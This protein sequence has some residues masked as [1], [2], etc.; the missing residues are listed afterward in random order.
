MPEGVA[1]PMKYQ[2]RPLDRLDALIAVLLAIAALAVY[3]RTL[4]PD[5][6]YGDSAEFQTLT[7]TLGHTHSTGY[8][9]YLF[10]AR[11]VGFLP[12]H[13]PAWRVSLFSAIMAAL[14]V[15][16]VYLVA[17]HLTSSRAGATL[18]SL[19]LALSYTMWSQ[20]VISEVYAPAAAFLAW[21]Y[22]LVLRWQ[23]DPEHCSRSLFAGGLLSGLSLGMHATTALAALPSAGLV[24]LWLI[25]RR[26]KQ[27]EWRK[28][29]LAGAGGA[30]LGAFIFFL[31]FLYIDWH[32]PSASFIN[33]TLSP[34]RAIWGLT[35]E[36]LDTPLERIVLTLNSVQ[37]NDVLFDGG[38]DAAIGSWV[39]Y[40]SYM[41]GREFSVGFLLLGLFGWW[42]LLP[43][44]GW[45]G[46]YLLGSFLVVWFYTLNYHPY[47]QYVFFLSTY[48][49]FSAVAGVG[50]GVLIEKL[51]HWKFFV[52]RG[53][54]RAVEI[55]L[56]VI[57][58]AVVLAPP[59]SK[60]AET[61]QSGVA[62]FVTETYQ[63]PVESLSEPRLLARMYLSQ[64]PDDAVVLMEWRNLHAVS[65]LAYVEGKKP[66]LILLEAMPRGNDGGLSSSLI[67]TIHQ[68]LAEGRPVLAAQRF[69]RLAENFRLAIDANNFVRVYEKSER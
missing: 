27:A 23:Q 60:R 36:D 44:T 56:I 66:D 54:G 43:R 6:L 55:F 59:L 24:L 33:T 57:L 46:F 29:L 40:M 12:F 58:A 28:T 69:P 34:S 3:V 26:A 47:D 31:G 13:S 7:Y 52:K 49:A 38:T 1:S 48:I 63:F 65:Y 37:W 42:E 11:L 5:V 51:T 45:R 21:I 25:V 8:P 61:I 64:F 50:I 62:T 18:G 19:G 2:L 9:I 41:V 14:A 4:A 35:P 20:A 30:L 15:A 67:E 32:N 68:A 53:W 22:L 10:L 17:R 16:G 39:D